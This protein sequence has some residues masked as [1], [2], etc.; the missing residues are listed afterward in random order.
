MRTDQFHRITE[1]IISACSNKGIK[2]CF[3]YDFF[4]AVVS[5]FDKDFAKCGVVPVAAAF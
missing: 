4:V 2:A 1:S 3:H 5:C